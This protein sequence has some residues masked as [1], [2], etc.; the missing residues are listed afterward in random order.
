[1]EEKKNS[2]KGINKGKTSSTK[3]TTKSTTAK[4]ATKT[5]SAKKVVKSTK[6]VD[7][8]T[9]PKKTSKAVTKTTKPAAK[10]TKS[11][12]KKVEKIETVKP[13][14]KEKKVVTKSERK[15]KSFISKLTKNIPFLISTIICVV[16][17]IVIVLMV[18]FG[19]VPKTSDGKQI[20]ATIKG[21]TITADDLYAEL[22]DE[23]GVDALINQIDDY[24]ANKTVTSDADM[25]E[26]DE[27]V[28]EVVDYYKN[29]AEQY[30]VEFD[31]FLTQY[32]GISG[33]TNE[34]E[35]Y[36]YVLKDYKKTLAVRNFIAE[37]YSDKEV[38]KYYD[39]NYSQSMSVKHILIEIEDEDEEA[40]KKQAKELIDELKDVKDNKDK[41]TEKFDEL[42]Y[43]YSADS[44][45]SSGG[46]I[47]NFSKSDVVEEFWNASEKLKDGEFTTEAVKTEYGYHIILKVSSNEGKALK[48]VEDEVRKAL[49]KE[50]LENDSTLSITAWDELRKEYKLEINDKKINELYNKKIE[51]NK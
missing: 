14:V 2:K 46:L 43:D 8:K 16:L 26:A 50:E 10:T 11:A 49:A 27:Y 39:D 45:Y 32:V 40:A 31:E 29:Y 20:V 33:V 41:L 1:M 47:E 44:T 28:K 3:S 6:K 24:I 30:G 5:T 19:G 35:F 38:K 12:A 22:K 17:I 4:N 7:T 15:N 18:I 13:A 34:D 36:N 51:S 37:G 9:A 25:E 23:Y 42:A 48:E 21:K